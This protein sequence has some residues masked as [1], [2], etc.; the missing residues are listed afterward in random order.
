[1][2]CKLSLPDC[3]V[4]R[5]PPK[6]SV[7]IMFG[8]LTDIKRDLVSIF[9]AAI[10]VKGDIEEGSNQKPLLSTDYGMFHGYIWG[11]SY[12]QAATDEDPNYIALNRLS[13]SFVPALKAAHT[14]MSE[15]ILIAVPSHY[16]FL[17][18]LDTYCSN[19]QLSRDYLRRDDV[20]DKLRRFL[21]SGYMDRE[22]FVKGDELSHIVKDIVRFIPN[23]VNLPVLDEYI[24]LFSQGA[25]KCFGDFYDRREYDKLS[26]QATEAREKVLAHIRRSRKRRMREDADAYN[27]RNLVDAT[28]IAWAYILRKSYPNRYIC[29]GGPMPP[30]LGAKDLH[31]I[32]GEYRSQYALIVSAKMADVNKGKSQSDCLDW[33]NMII[34]EAEKTIRVVESASLVSDLTDIRKQRLK[35]FYSTIVNG[36][37]MSNDPKRSFETQ[38]AAAREIFVDRRSVEERFSAGEDRAK[39][40]AM[41][42]LQ[43]EPMV[44][45]DELLHHL[46]IEDSP[47]IKSLKKKYNYKTYKV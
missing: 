31:E 40:A 42:L 6:K 43:I 38:I 46:Q 19:M 25:L 30:G 28:N 26:D 17:N 15:T 9:E 24:Q 45:S 2:L 33:L 3:S 11:G 12:A 22:F 20:F 44:M 47:R 32:V 21:D 39:T 18:V 27:F 37:L 7:A 16:E 5:L 35:L 10:Q 14:A 1:V 8:D 29:F 13:R 34:E 41:E 36:L 4:Q 23:T